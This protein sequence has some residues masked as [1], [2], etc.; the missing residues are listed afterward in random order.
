[1][2]KMLARFFGGKRG[3]SLPCKSDENIGLFS[4]FQAYQTLKGDNERYRERMD[5]I[6]SRPHRAT[7]QESSTSVQSEISGEWF[8]FGR[9][10]QDSKWSL[11]K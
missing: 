7:T 6:A 8:H 5:E 4:L 10:L 3:E 1:M 2:L 11:F 9:L